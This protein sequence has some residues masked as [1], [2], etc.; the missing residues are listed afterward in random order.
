[1]KITCIGDSLTFGYGVK[2]KENFVNL[3]KKNLSVEI[4]NKGQNG[5][6]SAGMLNRFNRDVLNTNCNICIILAGTND[7]FSNRKLEDIVDNTLFMVSECIMNNIIPIVISPPK[8]KKSL[9]ELYWSN[10]IDYNKTNLQLSNLSSLLNKNSKKMNFIFI[11]IFD[12]I[13]NLDEYYTDGVHLSKLSYILISDE[14]EKRI[15]FL[16]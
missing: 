15:A 5:D 9:A 13:P 7:I 2:P 16:L 8:T 1:M 10:T 14:I 12:L 6:S 11:D 3:L 4:L